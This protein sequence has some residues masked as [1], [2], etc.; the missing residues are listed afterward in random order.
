[1][2]I[3]KI[4]TTG[5]LSAGYSHFILII[6]KDL[7]LK[8]IQIKFFTMIALRYT[9]GTEQTAAFNMESIFEASSL[10]PLDK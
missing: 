4:I 8:D 7:S 1:M 5:S 6:G 3:L 2:F 9:N 10:Y